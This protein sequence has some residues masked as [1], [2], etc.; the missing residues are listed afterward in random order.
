MF[1]RSGDRWATLTKVLGFGVGGTNLAG[2]GIVFGGG[3]SRGIAGVGFSEATT[4]LWGTSTFFVSVNC[5]W[6]G[7]GRGLAKNVGST[8]GF[9]GRNC[10]G[11]PLVC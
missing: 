11:S 1:S 3:F 4:A 6:I 2:C 9:G 8:C 5:A 10:D 7:V